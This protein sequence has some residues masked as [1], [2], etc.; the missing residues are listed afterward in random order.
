MYGVTCSGV[1]QKVLWVM[2]VFQNNQVEAKAVVK[3]V[4]DGGWHQ[5]VIT[6]DTTTLTFYID[7]INIGQRWE[8]PPCVLHTLV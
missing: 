2:N 3:P 8:L 4:Q 7:G 6:M 1:N 5:V